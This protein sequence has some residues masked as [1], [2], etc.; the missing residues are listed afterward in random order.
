MSKYLLSDMVGIVSGQKSIIDGD[1]ENEVVFFTPMK[2]SFVY[3]VQKGASCILSVITEDAKMLYETIVKLGI[4]EFES[5]VEIK[6]E[7]FSGY[8]MLHISFEL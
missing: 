1:F 8:N 6:S 2:D 4:T 5:E 7:A 3:G